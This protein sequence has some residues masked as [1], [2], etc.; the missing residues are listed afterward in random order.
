MSDPPPPSRPSSE[1]PAVALPVDRAWY[2]E[3]LVAAVV[4]G[5]IVGLLALGYL[6]ATGVLSDVV[7]GDPQIEAWSGEWWWIPYTAVGGVVVAALRHRWKVA[8]KVPGGVE[9]IQSGAVDHRVAPSWVA[10]A[11]V[12]A[13]V[14]ASLGPSFALVVMGGGLGAWVASRRWPGNEEARLDATMAGV[15]GGFGGA[16]T[17]PVLGTMIVSELAPTPRARYVEALVPQLIAAA[18]A[19]TVYFGAVGSTFLNS[20]AIPVEDFSLWHLAAG[21]AF[22]VASTV[23][24]VVFVVIVRLAQV[25][26]GKL[27]NRYLRGLL[28]GAIVGAIA[29]ALPLT[30]G[31][32]NDQLTAVIED[33]SSIGAGLLLAVVLGKMV[34]VAVSLSTGFVGG[35]V[36]PM[37]FVG[38]TAGAA[39]HVLVPDV[40]YAIAVGSMMGAV[41]G[42]FIRAP[43]A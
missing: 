39:V 23:V 22:G 7:F 12:S 21:V 11:F 19:F 35:N 2:R 33:S 28:G 8:E 14:G 40:P 4:V 42:A 37:L 9:V 32:G 30:I 41:P 1:R 10:V 26:M 16:F 36:L 5:A 17:A 27:P 25:A 24:L 20:F 34:A 18:L 13:V 31:A 15:A 3:V 29:A 38:G 43:S 6:G